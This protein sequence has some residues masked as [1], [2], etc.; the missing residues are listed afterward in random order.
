LI[1]APRMAKSALKMEGAMRA[2]GNPPDSLNSLLP[3]KL[4]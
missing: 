4:A 1:S 3:A 2:M